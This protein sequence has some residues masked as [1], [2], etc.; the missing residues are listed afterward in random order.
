MEI[1]TLILYI[2]DLFFII[3]HYKNIKK[4][5]LSNATVLP[6]DLGENKENI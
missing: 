5:T 3:K 1:M 6:M 4:Q 2:A